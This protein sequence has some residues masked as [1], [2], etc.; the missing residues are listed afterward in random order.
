MTRETWLPSLATQ[1]FDEAQTSPEQGGRD[2]K[3]AEE[4]EPA[5]TGVEA[6]W[7]RMGHEAMAWLEVGH[8]DSR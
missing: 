6:V 3:G 1:E 2:E 8:G 5:A 4:A 7:R